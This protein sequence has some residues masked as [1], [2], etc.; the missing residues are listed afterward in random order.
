VGF[1]TPFL[2]HYEHI[3][4]SDAKAMTTKE[5]SSA[6]SVL[7][8]REE[9][10]VDRGRRRQRRRVRRRRQ[11][12]QQSVTELTHSIEIIRNCILGITTVMVV[13][14]LILVVVVWQIGNEAQRIKTEVQEIK[15]EA[16]AIVAQIEY[17]A[18]LIRDKIRHPLQ[19]IGGALGGQL[20][21][22][23]GSALGL[24]EPQ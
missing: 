2:I 17:E 14:L 4:E 21:Q 11:Q 3:M 6:V 5:L 20:D 23:I 8:E 16:E 18:D 9:S 1:P 12:M 13:S 22:K 7:L 19:T 24:P 10:R 15:G